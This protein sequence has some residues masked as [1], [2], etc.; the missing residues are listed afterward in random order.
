MSALP[1]LPGEPG[2]PGYF[3]P[4]TPPQIAAVEN[5]VC[6]RTDSDFLK[7]YAR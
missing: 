4:V 7:T 5:R 1:I 2:E 3:T 6:Y